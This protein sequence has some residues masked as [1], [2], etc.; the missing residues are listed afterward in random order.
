MIHEKNMKT[1]ISWHCLCKYLT[2]RQT[3][4]KFSNPD[5]IY[6]AAKDHSCLFF[7]ASP[8]ENFQHFRYGN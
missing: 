3:Y 1:K 5:P 4:I 8:I 7:L 2:I 6:L